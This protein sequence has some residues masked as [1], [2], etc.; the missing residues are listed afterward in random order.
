MKKSGISQ[1]SVE[2]VPEKYG[3]GI[4]L[5]NLKEKRAD[6]RMTAQNGTDLGGDES[7]DHPKST[8]GRITHA[9]AYFSGTSSVF[10]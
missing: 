1:D 10:F 7:R 5:G 3:A 2:V 4:S 9:S 6:A 8:T